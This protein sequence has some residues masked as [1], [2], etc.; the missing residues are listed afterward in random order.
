MRCLL[1]TGVGVGGDCLYFCA[2]LVLYMLCLARCLCNSDSFLRFGDCAEY[3]L[4]CL[5]K[6]TV[7]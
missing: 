3:C 5:C 7:N 4:I 2:L 6:Y 1:R